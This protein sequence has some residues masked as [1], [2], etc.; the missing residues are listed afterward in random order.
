M[1]MYILKLKEKKKT[2]VGG[3]EGGDQGAPK[4]GA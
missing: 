3:L 2:E 4:A 1:V